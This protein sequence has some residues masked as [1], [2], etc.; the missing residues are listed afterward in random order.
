MESRLVKFLK[1]F[2]LPTAIVSGIS[3]YLL[4]HF[5]PGLH[6]AGGVLHKTAVEGQRILVALMLFLQFVKISPHDLKFTKWHLGAILF[7]GL[8]FVA[9]ALIAVHTKDQG[10]KILLECAMLCLICPTAS[11][12]G[13]ITERLGGNLAQTVTYVVMINVLATF[14]IPAIIPLVKPS[15]NLPFWTYV[16]K[17]GLRIFPVLILPSILAWTIRYT[18]HHLQRWLM[19]HAHWSFYIWGICLTLAMSLATRALISSGLSLG[20]IGCIVLVSMG[21]CALQFA[22]GRKSSSDPVTKITAGQALGQKNTGFL[23]WLGYS[24]MTPVTSVAGGL[25]AIW[26]NLFN[27]WELY[28][29]NHRNDGSRK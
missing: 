9:V 12:A 27:S 5:I 26:Q 28:E 29:K 4:Y 22:A 13:V 1:D 14:L 19:R 16:W 23:I 17:I 11:A 24:Y 8:S 15:A 3:L 7:Q 10:I 18:T 2:M 21:C 20:L 25:Y 6:F